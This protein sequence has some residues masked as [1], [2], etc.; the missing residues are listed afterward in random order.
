[1][2]MKAGILVKKLSAKDNTIF[3]MSKNHKPVLYVDSGETIEVE[4]MDA[5]SNQILV[6]ED[7]IVAIDWNQINPATGPIFVNQAEKGDTLKV[8]IEKINIDSQGVLLT[9]PNLGMLGDEF[10]EMTKKIVQIQ[11]GQVVFN[12]RLSFPLT[13]MIG[14]IGVAP[15]HSDIPC[16]T[17]ESHGGNM[18][19]TIIKEGSVLYL[20]VFV[21]GA[22]LALGD[23]H[24]AMGDGEIC[25][26]GVEIAG[27]AVLKIEVVKG[28][29]IEHPRVKY[30]EGLSFIVSKETLDEAVK[31]ATKQAVHFLERNTDLSLEEAAMLMS[32]VGQAQISQV[33]DPLMTARFLI[34][35]F[36]LD[37]YQIK[38]F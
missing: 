13:K 7:T 29:A 36:V 37:A 6:E 32:A 24:G 10:N 20:P 38:V 18:D 27:S 25:G 5:L 34:P 9:G 17:P 35:Q 11:D 8:T 31:E 23:F 3:E 19:T 33:V 16:G 30:E 2:K 12:D 22:L 26:T 14:V 28:Q 4:T 15:E 21:D 1:M